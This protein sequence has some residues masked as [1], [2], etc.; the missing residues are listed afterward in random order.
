[1]NFGQY[2]SKYVP[3]SKFT[4][5]AAN[6]VPKLNI[7]GVNDIEQQV[8]NEGHSTPKAKEKKINLADV[9]GYVGKIN[10][11]RASRHGGIINN[12]NG[13]SHLRMSSLAHSAVQGV[14]N[15]SS[16]RYNFARELAE[17]AE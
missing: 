12:R 17:S 5:K 10:Q 16:E 4:P 9:D 15:A 13:N 2:N 7:V 14:V 1:M 8:Q 3:P 6:F 11:L